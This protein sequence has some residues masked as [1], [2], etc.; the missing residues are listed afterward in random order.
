MREAG[1]IV[2]ELERRSELPPGPAERFFGYG[3]MGA[4]RC[5]PD[6]CA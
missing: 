5:A 1:D 2:A 4:P 3:V 6:A